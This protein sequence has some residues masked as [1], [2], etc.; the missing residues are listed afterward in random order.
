[1]IFTRSVGTVP[2]KLLLT[3]IHHECIHRNAYVRA[4]RTKN[5]KQ[6]E[7]IYTISPKLRFC[8]DSRFPN[9]NG[10]TPVNSFAP[11]V[12]KDSKMYIKEIVIILRLGEC[13]LTYGKRF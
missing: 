10:M 5:I 12:N 3:A 7:L 2:D 4:S 13:A 11:I 8:K 1:M 9:S 6:T